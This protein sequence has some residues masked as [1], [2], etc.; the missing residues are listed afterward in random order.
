[1]S[2]TPP[3]G[4]QQ[5][6]PAADPVDLTPEEIEA[7]AD[8][9]NAANPV[10]VRAKRKTKAL[11][12]KKQ[13][14]RDAKRQLFARLALSTEEGREFFAWLLLDV[15]GL[16]RQEVNVSKDKDTMLFLAGARAGALALQETLLRSDRLQY[17]AML[18]EFLE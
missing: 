4:S 9:H 12:D 16:M 11:I 5:T 17:M 2:D 3:P 15:L 6:E 7:L 8:P 1:M 18:A 13:R 10:A 14:E